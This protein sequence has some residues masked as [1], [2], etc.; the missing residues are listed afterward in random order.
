MAK[1]LYLNETSLMNSVSTTVLLSGQ[2]LLALLPLE[3]IPTFKT[4]LLDLFGNRRFRV[5][6]SYK[7]PK[8]EDFGRVLSDPF[9]GFE[10][11][12]LVLKK[13]VDT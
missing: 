10:R 11:T 4:S 9:M 3:I 1:S 5:M 8:I 6:R 12:L 13:Q 2:G 7:R